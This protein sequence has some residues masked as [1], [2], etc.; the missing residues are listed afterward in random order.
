MRFSAP[1]IAL[2]AAGTS[3][4]SIRSDGQSLVRRD[5]LDVPGQ[6]PLKF[7]EADRAKDIITI[8]EVIL[9]PNPPQA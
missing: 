2:L 8:D 4:L 1:V 5:E 7:C 6:S 9:T 3:A